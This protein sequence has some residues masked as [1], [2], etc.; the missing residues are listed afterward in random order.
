[1]CNAF[2]YTHDTIQMVDR[3]VDRGVM[4]KLRHSPA[5]Q[6]GTYDTFQL[7]DKVNTGNR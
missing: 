6:S 7:G 4:G 2:A 1:M 3:Q 5:V